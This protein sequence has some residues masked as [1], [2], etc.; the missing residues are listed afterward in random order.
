VTASAIDSNY[1]TSPLTSTQLG[2]VDFPFSAIKDALVSVLGRIIRTY[3]S[4]PNHPFRAYNI[5]QTD[6]IAHKGAIP[7]VSSAASGNK[8]I[9]GAYGAIRDAS[10]SEILTKMP[11]QIVQTIV[12]N[13]DLQLKGDYHYYEIVDDR[14]YHTRTNAK[15]DVVTFSA[16]DILTAIGGNGDAPIP[17]AC[18]DVAW[19][20]L[21]STLFVDDEFL[22]QA[23]ICAQYFENC[24]AEIKA[25]A[26]S[27][28]PVP[29]TTVSGGQ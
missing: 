3:A 24:L 16:P 17:D 22:G 21:V 19:T 4:V 10:D 1:T 13:P 18:L 5:L 23:Q 27:F 6:N 28:A 26:V 20:G 11:V 25:G 9:V 14:L 15:I 8:A 7:S 12:E 2:S 29:A